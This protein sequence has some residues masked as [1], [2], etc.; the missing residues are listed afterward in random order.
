MINT[1][2]LIC[3]AQ[4]NKRI[5]K[6]YHFI[7]YRE[8]TKVTCKALYKMNKYYK[9]YSYLIVACNVSATLYWNK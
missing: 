4:L 6:T 8:R 2:L 7:H 1:A 5:T 9:E 3:I